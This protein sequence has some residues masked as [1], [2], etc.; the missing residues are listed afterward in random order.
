[1]QNSFFQ[2]VSILSS[3]RDFLMEPSHPSKNS[4]LMFGFDHNIHQKFSVILQLH[5]V[6]KFSGYLRRKVLRNLKSS[7]LFNTQGLNQ[8]PGYD[9]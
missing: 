9:W 2:E 7:S 4:G 3:Q 5:N 6:V 1:M 8:F